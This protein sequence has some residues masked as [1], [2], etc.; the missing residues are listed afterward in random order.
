MVVCYCRFGKTYR[1]HLR[2]SSSPR[3]NVSLSKFTEPLGLIF[4]GLKST[5]AHSPF[6][7]RLYKLDPLLKKTIPTECK[8]CVG[9]FDTN[10]KFTGVFVI[11]FNNVALCSDVLTSALHL[12]L[13]SLI[14]L[15]LVIG[16]RCCPI[17]RGV[18]S[19]DISGLTL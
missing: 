12:K 14:F 1:S 13:N 6:I 16:N 5:L 17:T 7:F 11:L 2:G 4:V 3:R 10:T 19:T 8:R 18:F 15:F 9:P